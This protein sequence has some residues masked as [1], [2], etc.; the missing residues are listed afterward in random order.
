MKNGHIVLLIKFLN[1]YSIPQDIHT[2]R[3]NRISSYSEGV[4]QF[5][6]KSIDSDLEHFSLNQI[7]DSQDMA[8]YIDSVVNVCPKVTKELKF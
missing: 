5:L 1:R 8:K 4:K 3:I 2:V 6:Q 7:G